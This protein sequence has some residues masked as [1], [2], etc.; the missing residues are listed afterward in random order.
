QT[1]QR[2]ALALGV[3]NVR[4]A[5]A[6]LETFETSDTFDAV[7]GRLV[8]LF[9]SDPAAILRRLRRCLRPDGVVAL[10][11]IDLSEAQQVLE[12][13]KSEVYEGVGRWIFDA[14]KAGGAE[15]NMGRQLPAAFLR[16]GLP[17]PTMIVGGRVESG[18]LSPAYDALAQI[19]RSLLPLIERAG[20]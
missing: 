18:P 20:L 16:A 8:L 19:V 1:A 9:L 14:F 2:R 6:E 10:Q 13:T 5:Q 15:L 11:E 4:F 7:I 12:M 17:R 3:T